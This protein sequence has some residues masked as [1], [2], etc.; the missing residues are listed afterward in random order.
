MIKY[1]I[2][3]INKPIIDKK[4]ICKNNLFFLIIKN[5]FNYGDNFE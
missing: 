5:K 3:I 1:F 4:F 2:T